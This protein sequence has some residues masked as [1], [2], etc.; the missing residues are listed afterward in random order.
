MLDEHCCSIG[1]VGLHSLV[2]FGSEI[3]TCETAV[4]S[5]STKP[6]SSCS[7]LQ[8]PED[9][10]ALRVSLREPS[11]VLFRTAFSLGAMASW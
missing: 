5:A 11:S 7:D 6:Q 4:A 2:L 8:L 1:P 9:E 3:L 10:G